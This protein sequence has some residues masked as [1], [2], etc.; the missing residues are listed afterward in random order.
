MTYIIEVSHK[1][2]LYVTMNIPINPITISNIFVIIINTKYTTITAI[3]DK[4][5]NKTTSM[6]GHHPEHECEYQVIDNNDYKHFIL[7][8]HECDYHIPTDHGCD[9]HIFDDHDHVHHILDDYDNDQHIL[10]SKLPI[11]SG[12]G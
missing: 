6:A 10:W 12:I 8:N 9:F 3:I 4:N 5:A 1:D 7:G 2:N 11:Q